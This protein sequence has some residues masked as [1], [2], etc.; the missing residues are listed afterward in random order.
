[1]KNV[2]IFLFFLSF[3]NAFSNFTLPKNVWRISVNREQ[4]ISQWKS[5]NGVN[6]LPQEVFTLK[7]F[8]LKYFDHKNEN[9]FED[10]NDLGDLEITVSE[11]VQK[12]ITDFNTL[13]LNEGWGFELFDFTENFFGNDSLQLIGQILNSDSKFNYNK[14]VYDIEFGISNKS[15]FIL[16]IP[17]FFNAYKNESWSWNGIKF[18]NGDI[19]GFLNYHN[20]NKTNFENIFNSPIKDSIPVF[21][22]EKI[23][24]VYDK[25]YIENEDY[26]ILWAL[27]SGDDPFKVIYDP[28]YNPFSQNMDSTSIDSI[29]NYFYPER[30]SNGLGD[31]KLGFNF[32][33]LG[34]P[35][36]VGESIFSIYGGIGLTIPSSKLLDKYQKN[37][38]SVPNQFK[39]L[40]LGKGISSL[41]TSLFG[42]FY[43]NYR[44][45][46]I[47][48][49]WF[50]RS[51]FNKEGK[52]NTRVSPRGT[53]TI[54][55]ELIL[56][57]LGDTYRMK[58]GNESLAHINASIELIPKR[59]SFSVG[60]YWYYKNRDKYFSKNNFWNEWMSGG[61]DIHKGYD[62][63]TFILYQKLSLVLNNTY[64]S[65]QIT[66]IPFE[67]DL[68]LNIPIITKHNWHAYR[69]NL[70]FI[71]YFQLW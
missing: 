1:M 69:L 71:T 6:R 68:S 38:L 40:P 23:N 21:M 20:S 9:S 52:F 24:S 7:N 12:I 18:E 51:T 34:S 41:N 15:T 36:W 25:Y 57:T 50:V 17:M 42:E 14:I 62:T 27:N 55:D 67:L 33:L 32:H 70:S 4:S 11:N 22:F 31:I 45:R 58:L 2:L 13:S 65:N 16:S 47:R 66:S 8:N 39:E 56:S 30:S 43:S 59:L 28:N 60:Q 53:F 48:F 64:F 10:L 61:N 54:N 26:S 5:S 46:L 37:D 44:S 49:N 29:L 3:L 19:E 63:K 35:V